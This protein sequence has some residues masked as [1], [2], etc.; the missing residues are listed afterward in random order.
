MTGQ[1]KTG[2]GRTGQDMVRRAWEEIARD[3]GPHPVRIRYPACDP[4]TLRPC[5]DMAIIKMLKFPPPT[6]RVRSL[7]NKAKTC[8]HADD[9]RLSPPLYSLTLSPPPLSSFPRSHSARAC[10]CPSIRLSACL[11]IC[12]PVNLPARARKRAH[13]PLPSCAHLSVFKLGQES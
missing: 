2:Y 10:G 11:S 7:F 12:L 8:M 6:F 5:D 3:T 13:F 1:A 9:S 4:A